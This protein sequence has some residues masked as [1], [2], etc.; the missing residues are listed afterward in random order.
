MINGVDVSDP[1]RALWRK[2]G[3]SLCEMVVISM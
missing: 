1:T 2:N 3:N